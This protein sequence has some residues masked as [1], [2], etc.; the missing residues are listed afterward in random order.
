[1]LCRLVDE[2]LTA[3]QNACQ[4]F[5][6]SGEV[7]TA[8]LGPVYAAAVALADALTELDRAD[9]RVLRAAQDTGLSPREY[10]GVKLGHQV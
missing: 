2:E 6:D 1:M 8:L 5:A 7:D 3:V 10:R 4:Y 9:Y